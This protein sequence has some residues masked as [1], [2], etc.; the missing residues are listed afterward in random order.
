MRRCR[1][2]FSIIKR[3]DSPYYYFKRGSWKKYRTK[4]CRTIEKLKANEA[5][6]EE[7]RLS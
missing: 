3:P 4:Q 2:P 7:L 1:E 6:D 5:C